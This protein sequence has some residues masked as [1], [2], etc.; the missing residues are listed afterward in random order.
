VKETERTVSEL[1][2]LLKLLPVVQEMETVDKIYRLLVAMVTTGRIVGYRRAMLFV[3]DE[4]KEIVSGRFGVVR[5]DDIDSAD[6]SAISFEDRARKVFAVY[7]GVEASDLTV[8]VRSFT[9]P[10]AWHRSALVKAARTTYPVLAD[11]EA[12]EYATDPFFNFFDSSCYIAVPLKI[13]KRVAAVL[14]ADGGAIRKRGSVDEISLLY[15]LAQQASVAAQNLIDFSEMRRRSR[16]ARKLQATLSEADTRER[17]EEGLRLALIMVARAVGGSGCLLKDLTRQKTT[18]IK[19]VHEY[20]PEAGDE[21]IAIA[22]C[23]DGILD[24][25]AAKM[26]S[27]VGDSEHP[28]LSSA[29]AKAV[30]HFRATPLVAGVSVSGAIAVYKEADGGLPQKPYTDDDKAFIDLCASIIA[31]KLEIVQLEERTARGED[32]L[33]EVSSNLARERER[34]RLAER[35]LDFHAQITD[36]L[37]TLAGELSSKETYAKRFAK[38]SE[39]LK[40][41]RRHSRQHVKELYQ[42]ESHYE[43]MDVFDLTRRIVQDHSSLLQG[44]GIG[45]TVRIPSPGPSLLMDKTKIAVAVENILR[46]TASCLKKG[47]KMLVECSNSQDRVLVCFADNSAGLPGDAISRLVMPFSEAEP[48]DERK[49]ALSLAGE[50]IQKHSG[51]I[52]IKSSMSWKTILIMS[53]P[54]SANRDRRQTRRERRRRNERR[55]AVSPR[56]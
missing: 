25:A 51:E 2:L 6:N 28:L 3:V 55:S 11:R 21:D 39:I 54:K 49:R 37:K 33:Q 43:R 46:A 26:E 47:D 7:E 56:T 10:L 22:E 52:L 48:G 53:F 30:A 42:K 31:S 20:S 35:S 4:R 15:S 23:F 18:H 12:A 14:V 41:M 50:I 36:D 13:N 5:P 8:Q 19:T 16:I 34:S 24:D 40:E 29:A 38:I 44:R 17:L 32:F 45:L 1:A 27:I 9:V